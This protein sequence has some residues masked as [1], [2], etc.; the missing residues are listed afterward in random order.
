MAN[1]HGR[2]EQLREYSDMERADFGHSARQPFSW[3]AE[4][5]MRQWRAAWTTLGATAA[6]AG[7]S[8]SMLKSGV[9]DV[10]KKAVGNLYLHGQWGR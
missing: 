10:Q 3:R 1:E 2:H 4:D 5:N 7:F 6:P 9:V 8:T